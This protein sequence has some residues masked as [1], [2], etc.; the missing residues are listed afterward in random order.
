MKKCPFQI[1]VDTNEKAPYQFVGMK[2]RL[3]KN[4]D[5]ELEEVEVE[6]IDRRL[7]ENTG[8]YQIDGF[9]LLTSVEKKEDAEELYATLGKRDEFEEQ[10]QTMDFFYRSSFI[11]VGDTW[12]RFCNPN[13][14]R[15]RLNW[16]AR[17]GYDGDVSIIGEEFGEHNSEQFEIEGSDVL[18]T[19][20]AIKLGSES[21]GKIIA[22][23]P[24]DE[25]IA[26]CERSVVNP[27][28]RSELNPRAAFATISSWE[29]RYPS[30][31]W[32]FAGERQL[33]EIACFEKLKTAWRHEMERKRK[34][35]RGKELF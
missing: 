25:V 4:F 30:V 7:K 9:P 3:G 31:H 21:G 23:G 2:M 32:I 6:T 19:Y 27:E 11:I 13:L 29:E 10:V 17:G 8:D 34:A 14:I 22:T 28:W 33:A 26:H 20:E 1:V 16:I 18:G 12:E 15:K 24:L 35:A 5:K